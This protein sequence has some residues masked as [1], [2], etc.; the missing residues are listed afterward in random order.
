ML[1][2]KNTYIKELIKAILVILFYFISYSYP[3]DSL[4]NL[5]GIKLDTVGKLIAFS[6]TYEALILAVIIYVYKKELSTMFKDYKANFKEYMNK[7]FKYWILI[8]ILMLVSNMVITQFTVS[9]TS[10]NQEII[11]D[12]LKSAPLYIIIT[13]IFIAPLLEETI[14]RFCIRKI[15]PKFDI[16]Y[17]IVSGILFGS[18]HVILTFN[19]ITDLLFIIPYSIPGI[20]FA[21]LYSKTKNIFVPTS[22]HFIHNGVLILLEIV[23]NLV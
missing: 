20:I 18:L 16:L 3:I 7:Y 11:I 8:L 13:T 5:L 9:E 22:I 12:T 23:L 6:I 21:Y 10:N 17:I 15:I 4:T 1:K 14:F 2:E 19:D